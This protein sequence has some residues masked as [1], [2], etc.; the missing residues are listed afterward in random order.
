MKRAELTHAPVGDG[1]RAEFV[2]QETARVRAELTGGP[3]AH[4][5]AE[6]TEG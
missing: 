5:R 1:V 3:A 2:E 4:V 6:L